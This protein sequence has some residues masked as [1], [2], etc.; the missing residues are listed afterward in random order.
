MTN[1][2]K[3]NFDAFD[4]LIAELEADPVDAENLAKARL[5]VRETFYQEEFTKDNNQTE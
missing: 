3:K 5:W 1:Q 2:P 4:K